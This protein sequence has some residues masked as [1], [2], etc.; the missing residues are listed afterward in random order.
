VAEPSHPEVRFGG[1]EDFADGVALGPW[2]MGEAWSGDIG[3]EDVTELE[4][5]GA[6]EWAGEV[7]ERLGVDHVAAAIS[8]QPRT[9]VQVLQTTVLGVGATVAG[10]S[11]G[12]DRV[13]LNA[14]LGEGELIAEEEIFH[15]AGGFGVD[16]DAG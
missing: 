14:G 12:E 15:D 6:H 4:V 13:S 9:K 8:K 11:V 7:V 10:K 16:N 1:E 5:D 3:F 2:E